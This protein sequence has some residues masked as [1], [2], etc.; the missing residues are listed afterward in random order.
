MPPMATVTSLPTTRLAGLSNED[1]C[2]IIADLLLFAHWRTGPQVADLIGNE[3]GLRNTIISVLRPEQPT[4]QFPIRAPETIAE[5][6][7]FNT[8]QLAEV[9][10]CNWFLESAQVRNVAQL[11]V[12]SIEDQRNTLIVE[13]HNHTGLDTQR[14]LQAMTTWE[15]VQLASSW[16]LPRANLQLFH[17]LCNVNASTAH[18]FGAQAANGFGLDTLKIVELR[19]AARTGSAAPR[20]LG[21]FHH[22]VG[23]DIFN[24]YVTSSDNLTTWSEPILLAERASQGTF[25]QQWGGILLAFEKNDESEGIGIQVAFYDT[26]EAFMGGQPPSNQRFARDCFRDSGA[27]G[28]P[29]IMDVQGDSWNEAAIVLGLHYFK[30]SRIDQPGVGVLLNGAD[31]PGWR[32]W[33]LTAAR[34]SIEAVGFAGKIGDRDSFSW[35]GQQL[36]IMEAQQVLNQWSS[37][38]CVV[39][40][41]LFYTPLHVRTPL[42]NTAFANPTV[43]RLDDGRYVATMFIPAQGAPDGGSGCLIYEFP[44]PVP[45]E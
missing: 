33:P 18:T 16:H 38:R 44:G 4:P 28:T 31:T 35:R 17:S 25:C 11:A 29:S 23:N 43:S 15:L 22:L 1:A 26:V 24:L 5:L 27:M 20:Y 8:I 45:F 42:G 7:A 3:D 32:A 30:D 6:Q 39:G 13:N 2:G 36:T 34:L 41:G 37:W 19:G 40:N 21:V 10:L 12:M 9:A 14:R